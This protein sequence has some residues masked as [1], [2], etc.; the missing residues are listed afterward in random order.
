MRSLTRKVLD[1]MNTPIDPILEKI[2]S[3]LVDYLTSKEVTRDRYYS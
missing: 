3:G 1:A 2:H